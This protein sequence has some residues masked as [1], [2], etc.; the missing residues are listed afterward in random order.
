MATSAWAPEW[1][2]DS[3]RVA[4]GDQPASKGGGG[5]GAAKAMEEKR[6]EARAAVFVNS[7]LDER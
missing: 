7:I 1:S 5:G 3:W 6:A 2:L 4:V